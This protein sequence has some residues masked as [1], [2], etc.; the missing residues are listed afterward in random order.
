MT[1]ICELWTTQSAYYT[2][3]KS[4]WQ[5]REKRTIIFEEIMAENYPNYISR[6]LNELQAQETWIR[7]YQVTL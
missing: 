7:I 2:Q 6:K 5:R 4:L 3:F 1:V